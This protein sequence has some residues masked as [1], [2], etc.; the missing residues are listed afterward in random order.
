[1]ESNLTQ[2]QVDA[3]NTDLQEICDKHGVTISAQYAKPIIVVAPK[4]SEEVEAE[5]KDGDNPST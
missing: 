4:A 1:M 5:E 2:E 3:F